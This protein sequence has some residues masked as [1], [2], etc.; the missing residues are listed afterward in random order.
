MNLPAIQQQGELK[1]AVNARELHI[2]LQSKQQ[3][4]D[5]QLTSEEVA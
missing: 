5:E 1:Q 4:I 3:F 2:Y